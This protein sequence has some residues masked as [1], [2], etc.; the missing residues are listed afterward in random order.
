MQFKEKCNKSPDLLI[1]DIVVLPIRPPIQIVLLVVRP[2]PRPMQIV[3]RLPVNHIVDVVLE[4]EA[5]STG[6]SAAKY[7]KFHVNSQQHCT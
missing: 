3:D 1:I 2:E 6:E 5:L 7:L 4:V